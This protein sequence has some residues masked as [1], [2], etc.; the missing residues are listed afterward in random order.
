MA[1]S[2]VAGPAGSRTDPFAEHRLLLCDLRTVAPERERRARALA[3]VAEVLRLGAVGDLDRLRVADQ[4]EAHG[5]R[6]LRGAP[7]VDRQ[8]GEVARVGPR[9]RHPG[10][11]C[12]PA[13]TQE[14]LGLLR[15][16]AS[17][18]ERALATRIV[19]RTRSRT[20]AHCAIGYGNLAPTPPS[21]TR[22]WPVT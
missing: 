19:Q 11:G 3:A 4:L 21:T 20:G 8:P 10:A 7:R 14:R 13:A 22:V 15:P 17:R 5:R 6:D 2:P 1:R 12:E 18:S 16:R 9:V